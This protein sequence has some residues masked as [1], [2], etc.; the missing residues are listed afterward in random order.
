MLSTC[1]LLAQETKKIVVEHADFA[2]INQTEIP[3]ALLLT[4]NVRVR[5]EGMVVT[6]NKAYYFQKENYIKAFGN[7]NMV[8]GDTLFLSGKYAEYNGNVK[9]ALATGDVVM[10][11]KDMTLTTDTIH[12]DR[13]IQQAYYN[14]YG[15]IVSKD[16]TL[17]SKS[18]RYFTKERKYQFLTAV[19]LTNP[20]YVMKSDHLDYYTGPGHAYLFGPSTITSKNNY[21]YTENGFYDTRKN[22]A[23]FLKK[24]YIRYN[25]RRIEA[26]SLYYD[27]NREFASGTNNVKIT[28]TINKGVV[29]GHYAELYKNKDSLFVTRH[30]VAINLV[31]KDSAYIHGKIL[32]VTG[33][34]GCRVVRAYPNAR[35]FKTDLSG[36]CDSIHSS[37]ETNLTKLI[38]KPI[39][40]NFD[41]QMTGDVMH[42]VGD[43]KTQKL[44]SL[45]VLNNAFLIAKDTLGTGY[46]Q[47]KGVNLYG[48]F[49]DNKLYYAD[50]VKNTEVVYYMYNDDNELIGINKNV[51]SKINML[52]TDNAIDTITFFTNVDGDIYPEKDLP[53]N[54]R[55][56]RGFVW[57]GDERIMTKD[58]IFPPDEQAIDEKIQ[59]QTKADEGKAP[60]P[61]P[62]RK[63]TTDYDKHD[64]NAAPEA[65]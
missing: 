40:W 16:N 65:K 53:E 8:Q 45:K 9:Q 22:L 10:R 60:Q 63:E 38:G 61:M 31:E 54:A 25:D 18:G 64:G 3:D 34:E 15:T 5:Q 6:C 50:V 59:A 4:G 58:D 43:D 56:L 37:Q 57:R 36:K 47:V 11:S 12:F 62:L 49:R 30:A 13:N 29:K 42:L 35:F 28:D 2:D 17:K 21:I 44:D 7:V 33:P 23:H 41:K 39:L 20:K 52:M 19:T 14:S 24:S 48:K 46:N 1:A 26:D 32:M 51:S 55:K 27:R